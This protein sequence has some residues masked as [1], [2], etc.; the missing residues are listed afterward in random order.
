PDHGPE[1]IDTADILTGR[2]FVTGE[3]VFVG[4]ARGAGVRLLSSSILN[5][6]FPH[7]PAAVVDV[8]VTHP[9][10][11]SSVL[12][13]GFTF[14][15]RPTVVSV[16]SAAGSAAGSTAGGTGVTIAGTGFQSGATVLFGSAPAT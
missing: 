1:S 7:Q 5:S 10:G 12:S 4:A 2:N 6:T 15:A 16:A 9:D 14:L 11:R 13:H 8:A 3:Y